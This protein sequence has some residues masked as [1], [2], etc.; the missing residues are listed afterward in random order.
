MEQA[1][2]RS[3]H[4][5]TQK[6]GQV[7]V[8]GMWEEAIRS[9][10]PRKQ[11]EGEKTNKKRREEEGKKGGG[12]SYVKFETST[13]L[14]IIYTKTRGPTLRGAPWLLGKKLELL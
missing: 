14:L 2:E 10:M 7:V 6:E 11:Q 9:E 5:R 3:V 8:K 4:V 13:V 1:H 12:W